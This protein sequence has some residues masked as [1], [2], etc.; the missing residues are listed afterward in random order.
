MIF[1]KK[2]SHLFQWQAFPIMAIPFILIS[3]FCIG[4]IKP[5][6]ASTVDGF[7]YSKHF[8]DG[9]ILKEFISVFPEIGG[10]LSFDEV[11][12]M[13]DSLFYTV[14]DQPFSFGETIHFWLKFRITNDTEE[15]KSDFIA[16]AFVIDTIQV[17]SI[18]EGFVN[19]EI[20]TGKNIPPKLKRVP[21]RR[22]FVNF[23][24]NPGQSIE[25]Y[26]RA[27]INDSVNQSST[28]YIYIFENFFGVYRN[29]FFENLSWIFFAL[30]L[31][32][33]ALFALVIYFTFWEKI[34]IFYSLLM[35]CLTLYFLDYN[36]VIDFIVFKPDVFDRFRS[37]SIL[38]AG[39][40]A[41]TYLFVS[42]FLALPKRLPVFSKFYKII[43]I[44]TCLYSFFRTFIFS[45][46]ILLAVFISNVLTFIFV[47]VTYFVI[48]L[49]SFRKVK[50]AKVLLIS[51]F[52]MFLGS[53]F[54]T[55][56]LLDFIPQTDFT[57]N[58]FQWG[59]IAFSGTLFYGLFDQVTQI[60]NDRVRI[61][62]EREKSD[63]LLFNI[64]PYEVANELK[65]KGYCEARDF[66]RVNVLFTDFKNFTSTSAQMS[67]KELVDE[68]NSCFVNFDYIV[69]KYN[70]EKIKTIG[71][72][73]MAAS[74]LNTQTE[75]KV[76]DIVLAAIEMQEY[77]IH[78][79]KE[80]L[81]R[82][83]RVFEMRI[84]IHTGPVVAG[85][86]GVKKFQYDIWGD[87]VNTASRIETC[88][89][90]GK[91]NISNCTYE[92]IKDDPE[93]A[94]EKRGEIAVK[95]KGKILMWFVWRSNNR[96]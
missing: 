67:A 95:G 68:I 35:C 58:S 60:Q 15:R 10:R 85:I 7:Y 29:I 1:L 74:G 59:V 94:F 79:K 14:A 63:E 75:S 18:Q 22:S 91:V 54:F 17:F 53:I 57:R 56:G 51:M 36:F 31:F 72:A 88:G 50:E 24:L 62:V 87:T 6:H 76:S 65:E 13:P 20:T 77:L 45:N 61:K 82:N 69:E 90:V 25:F 11:R 2:I 46:E 93:F 3:C 52:F 80:L 28:F 44:I 43:T 84:G 8:E 33:F 30:I 4:P 12:Q 38:V 19:F 66:D 96:T 92:F 40:I 86:V 78:R 83:Q 41:F 89:E 81:A 47:I 64:L 55:L 37:N 21:T 34:F 49:L 48:I 26:I 27:S 42:R 5:I 32:L 23:E 39:I 9:T 70:I 71:D 16:S 73:Y